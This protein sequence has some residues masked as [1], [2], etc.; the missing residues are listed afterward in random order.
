MKSTTFKIK[1]A[2]APFWSLFGRFGIFFIRT[3][4]HTAYGPKREKINFNCRLPSQDMYRSQL[5]RLMD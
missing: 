5:R 4:G 1:T 2:V 3:S